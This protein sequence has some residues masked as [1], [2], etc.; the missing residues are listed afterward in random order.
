[1]SVHNGQI[2][3][4]EWTTKEQLEAIK[5]LVDAYIEDHFS[6]QDDD[7]LDRLQETVL[8]SGMFNLACDLEIEGYE[9]S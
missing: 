5:R 9:M 6:N 4:L 1:M 3:V 8:Y 7:E 2:V